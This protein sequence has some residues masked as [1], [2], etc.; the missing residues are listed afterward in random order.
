MARVLV[1]YAWC[2][3]SYLIVRSLARQGHE[4]FT[5]SSRRPAAG[6]WSRF[7][8]G[9][10]VVRDPFENPDGFVEDVAG[11]A[12]RWRVDA[13][14]PGHEDAIPLRRH[15]HLLPDGVV[16]VA[17]PL[18]LLTKAVDKAHMTRVAAEAGVD[19][20]ETAHPSS[21]DEAIAE[22]ERIGFPVVV[23]LH[24][25]NGGKGVFAASDADTVGRAFSKTEARSVDGSGVTA[26]IQRFVRGTVVGA[27][28]IAK[29]G[30]TDVVFGE[31]Y[32]RTKDGGFG[33]STYRR[34]E[35]SEALD[36]ATHRLVGATTWTGLGHFDFVE[37]EGTGR[38]FFL[39]A[40]PRPWGAIHLAYVNGV[41]F[42]AAALGLALTSDP[43]ALST[44]AKAQRDIHSLWPIGEGIRLVHELQSVLSGRSERLAPLQTSRINPF[45]TRL[46]GLVWHDPLPFVAEAASYLRGFVLAGGDTNPRSAGMHE[47]AE[48]A[49]ADV[50]NRGRP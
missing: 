31:R 50:S 48:V 14:F 20:P 2:R 46:D 37:E 9:G 33:T 41:D 23:K 5:V 7:S 38:L 49:D 17:P 26:F 11:H 47:I 32:L 43:G 30:A 39:E 40:N 28:F 8:K 42:P 1:T 44:G 22:A 18:E 6:S 35:R 29:D 4:V 36:I 12:S 15:A 27:C 16:I 25:S 34:P 19:V 10:A 24:R 13:V 45:R 3:T 21:V